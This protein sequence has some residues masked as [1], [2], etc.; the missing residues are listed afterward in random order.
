MDTIFT[1]GLTI[2]FTSVNRAAT[3]ATTITVPST[4]SS[5]M[6][7]MPPTH[8]EVS[9]K[10]TALMM[11]LMTNCMGTVCH[12]ASRQAGE[13][14]RSGDGR[15]QVLLGHFRSVGPVVTA[16]PQHLDPVCDRLD[17]TEIMPDEHHPE[18]E[19]AQPAD[20]GEHLGGLGH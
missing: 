11:T 17:V 12:G 13:H 6:N 14:R 19:L 16:V 20:M 10:A 4:V 7:S 3:T 5:V 9:H 8:S 18:P 2:A 1:I 15:D